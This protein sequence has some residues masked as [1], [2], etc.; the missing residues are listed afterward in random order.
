VYNPGAFDPDGNDSLSFKL[1]NAL[2][3]FCEPFSPDLYIFPNQVQPTEPSPNPLQNLSIDPVTGTVTWEVPQRAGIYNLA[4]EV[5]EWR[6]GLMISKVLRDMQIDVLTCPNIPPVL[7]AISDTCVEAGTT[8]SIPIFANDTQGSEVTITGYGSPFVAPISQAVISQFS[9]EVPVTASFNWATVCEQVKLSPYQATIQATDNGPGVNLTDIETFNITV[10]APAPENLMAS[11]SGISIEVTWDA[12]VC[13]NAA[14]YKL[15]KRLDPFGYFP[16]YCETGVPAY[17]GYVEIATLEGLNNTTYFDTQITFGRDNCYMVIAYFEDGAESYASNEICSQV[18]FVMPIMK[19][20][21][22][23]VTDIAGVDTVHWRSPVQLDLSLFPGP[24]QYKLYGSNGYGN[25]DQIV[26]ETPVV[27]D[28]ALLE[29]EFIDETR[30]TSESAQTYRVELYSGDEFVVSSSPA[31]SLFL[32]LTLNDNEI[33]VN[34]TEAQDWSNFAYDVYRQDDGSGPFNLIATIDTIGFLDQ[35]LVN[36]RE[37]CYYIVS[38][39]SYN[40]PLEN[41]TLINFSQQI[42]GRPYD[43]TPP[44]APVLSGDGDCETFIVNLEWTNPNETCPETDDVVEYNIYFTP[45]EGQPMEVLETIVGDENTAIQYILDNSIAGCYAITALDTLAIW[46]DGE[47]RQNE[48]EM[49]NMICFDN[50]PNYL[51]PNVMTPNGDGKN[52]YFAPFPYRSVESIQLTIFNRWGSIV[53]ETTDPDIL[54]DGTSSETGELVSD[55]VYYYTCTVFSIRLTGLVPVNLSGY[56]TLFGDGGN[57][58]E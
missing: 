43:R 31:S 24:Y 39:G 37:Y 49:S 20:N 51:L 35:G 13:N 42:C 23:G 45:V 1:V 50:C 46:P 58:S 25:P 21:S 33:E 28:F 29:N 19:K 26:F 44:C 16:D 32:E 36:N 14:G 6:D 11:P 38:R 8:L 10:I 22:V 17:T 30:N 4:I 41:D 57:G 15:Y 47:L 12:S 52:D 48:S 5:E 27:T 55:G 54:W 53:F 7:T 56:V 34:W 2:G 3:P 18:E 9:E 40:S